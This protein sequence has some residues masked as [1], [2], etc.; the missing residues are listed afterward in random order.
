M[1]LFQTQY[2]Y[3]SHSTKQTYVLHQAGA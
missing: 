1:L 3:H 2:S